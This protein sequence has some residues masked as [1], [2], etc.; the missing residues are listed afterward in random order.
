MRMT[1]AHANGHPC[2]FE[3]RCS[4]WEGAE[5]SRYHP[6]RCS[7]CCALAPAAF[8]EWRHTGVNSRLQPWPY[9]AKCNDVRLEQVAHKSVASVSGSSLDVRWPWPD[10]VIEGIGRDRYK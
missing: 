3:A 5:W 10:T 1:K 6:G 4:A 8:I 9:C 2:V 7:I